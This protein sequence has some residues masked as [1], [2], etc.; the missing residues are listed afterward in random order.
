MVKTLKLSVALVLAVLCAS[1]LS[2]QSSDWYIGHTLGTDWMDV[3]KQ[4]G[5]NT[6]TVCYPTFLCP[7]EPEGYRWF[8]DL[9]TH[10]GF[11]MELSIGKSIKEYR[12]ELALVLAS[13]EI[14]QIYNNLT[15]LDRSPV[16]LDKNSEYS[17][18]VESRIGNISFVGLMLNSYRDFRMSNSI[19]L[20]TYIGVG[21]GVSRV[22]IEDLVFW[23]N[24]GCIN[25]PC[26]DQQISRFNVH[27]HTDLEDLVWAVNLS[28]GMDYQINRRVLIGLKL[29]HRKTDDLVRSAS[30]LRHPIP[31]AKNT[32]RISKLSSW[33]LS[34]SYKIKR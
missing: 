15:F 26:N 9:E 2:S 28:A 23:S 10:T 32:T 5:F 12:A 11:G 16:L 31:D 14:R 17:N 3:L 4:A 24:Y 7:E 8:Y 20:T 6:D 30:Y 1:N 22:Q 19:P 34:L 25:E 33:S 29:V 27:Q 21:L 18:E 13:N